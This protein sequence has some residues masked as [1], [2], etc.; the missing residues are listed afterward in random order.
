MSWWLTSGETEKEGETESHESPLNFKDPLVSR[1]L[2]L[3]SVKETS[4][5]PLCQPACR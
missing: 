5:Y 2:G 3:G 4:Y 1:G